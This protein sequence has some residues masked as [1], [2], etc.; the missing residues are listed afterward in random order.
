MIDNVDAL[1]I[2]K[3]MIECTQHLVKQFCAIRKP[4]RHSLREQIY[5]FTPF[6]DEIIY[7][8]ESLTCEAPAELSLKINKKMISENVI[9]RILVVERFGLHESY[10]KQGIASAYF[11]ILPSLVDGN[12]LI[13]VEVETIL[14]P[15]LIKILKALDYINIECRSDSFFKE[16]QSAG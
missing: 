3:V 2:T 13:G 4:L 14:N 12:I 9:K 10:Q 6:R 1:K 5:H 16:A 15:H 7:K 8:W 11:R